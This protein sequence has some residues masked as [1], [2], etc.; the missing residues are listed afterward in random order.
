MG[1]LRGS[2]IQTAIRL[3]FG[4]HPKSESSG[5]PVFENE[6]GVLIAMLAVAPGVFAQTDGRTYFTGSNVISGYSAEGPLNRVVALP[7]RYF[8]KKAST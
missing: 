7:L 1:V 2:K 3:S 6:S 8:P 4:S 5:T